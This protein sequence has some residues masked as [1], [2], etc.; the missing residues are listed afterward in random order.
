MCRAHRQCRLLGSLHSLRGCGQRLQYPSKEWLL[1]YKDLQTM[2]ML[3]A[4]L[5][6]Y[7]TRLGPLQPVFQL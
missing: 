1:A 5:M 2:F 3:H 4:F 7:S 6:Q